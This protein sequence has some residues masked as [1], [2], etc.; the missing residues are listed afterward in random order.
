[1]KKRY[2]FSKEQALLVIILLLAA[3]LRFFNLSWDGGLNIHPDEALIVNGALAIRFFSN[4]NPGFH[5]YNGLPVYVLRAVGPQVT[6][7]AE[8]TYL[9]RMITAAL[10]TLTVLIVFLLGKRLWGVSVGLLAAALLA[11][12][13]LAVQQAHFYTSDTFVVFFLSLLSLAV[14]EWWQAPSRKNIF[15]C[16]LWVGL[17]I[18]CKNT[19]Y[20]LLLMPVMAIILRKG[21]VQ[22]KVKDLVLL[23]A[24][25]VGVFT[26]ASPYSFLDLTGYLARSKYLADVVSGRL[27]FDWTVQFINT[28]PLFWVRNSLYAFG[29][30][31]VVLGFLGVL[32][33]VFQERGVKR[34]LALW[35]VIFFVLLAG[36]YLKFIRYLLPL[37]PLFVLFA[38]ALIVD[39]HKRVPWIGKII[40]ITVVALTWI[41]GIMFVNIYMTPHPVV[42]AA[43]WLAANAQSGAG[44]VR[45]EGNELLRFSHAPLS[46]KTYNLSL[47]R[48]YVLPD[49][50]EKVEAML[51]QI[52]QADFV[53]VESAKVRNTVTRLREQYPFT[54][55][56]YEALEDGSLGYALAAE[57]ISFPHLG[58][59][60]FND[61]GAEETFWVFD[62]PRVRVYKNEK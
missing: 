26:I 45:E 47:I 44:I 5:D 19:A 59:F 10:S 37:A 15:F 48:P 41:W 33:S 51:T 38:A 24:V 42:Q 39:L 34:I 50:E 28:T 9:G 16:A 49:T 6:S 60:M 20:I 27:Q 14:V 54:S 21:L 35:A 17:A 32:T 11:P 40:G 53:L 12:L 13:P 23:G 7:T 43:S 4:L 61:L 29:P 36:V 8:I 52:S 30:A 25:A 55:R 58:P 31:V 18:G 57:F 3:V 62:H 46:S 22:E 56:I 2:R 1:V